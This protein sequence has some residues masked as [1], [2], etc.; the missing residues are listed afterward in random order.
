MDDLMTSGRFA[1]LCGTTKE[2]LRHYDRL[3]LLRP[4]LRSENGY[5][6]YTLGQATGFFLIAALQGAGMSLAEVK[7][8]LH[9]PGATA[10]HELLADRIDALEQQKR[11]LERRQ[12]MMQD[13]LDRTARL[14]EWL[15]GD[16]E[17]MSSDNK[18]L[19]EEKEVLEVGEA[20]DVAE[21]EMKDNELYENLSRTHVL[22]DGS[23]WRIAR[24]HEAFFIETAAPYSQ[25]DEKT[26]LAAFTDHLSYCEKIGWGSSFQEAYRI[27]AASA[28]SGDYAA[29]FCAET[30]V[31]RRIDSSRLRVKPA[32]T[33]L[34]WL[35]RI[36]LPDGL[37]DASPY[38]DSPASP[39]L[40]ATSNA[41]ESST[42]ANPMFIAYDR[43]RAFATSKGWNLSGDIFDEVLTLYSGGTLNDVYTEVSM[44]VETGRT[45]CC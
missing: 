33:Y 5:K 44:L 45:P 18:T 38:P 23:R 16:G 30:R 35:N 15:A 41:D 1:A 10:I 24:C 19:N 42:Q 13:A 2:T 7:A 20:L 28:A 32:G 14:Q 37:I 27:D 22:P 4:A 43:I 8:F 9:Q 3:G 26:F 34:L 36:E 6:R 39:F 12:W 21:L 31:P 17:E 25:D 11:D 29:G 40:E